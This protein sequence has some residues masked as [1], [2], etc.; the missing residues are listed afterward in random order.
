MTQRQAV[1]V[2]ETESYLSVL[3]T[4]S[5]VTVEAAGTWA[6]EQA[7]IKTKD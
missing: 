2:D 3:P 6:A 4:A 1:P 7:N 5:Y